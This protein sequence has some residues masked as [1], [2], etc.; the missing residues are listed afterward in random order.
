[1]QGKETSKGLKEQRTVGRM[2]RKE[3][4]SWTRC[5]NMRER[6]KRETQKVGKIEVFEEEEME[7]IC[8]RIKR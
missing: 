8:K 1:M 6:W 2:K 3:E 7:R 5:M 4:W